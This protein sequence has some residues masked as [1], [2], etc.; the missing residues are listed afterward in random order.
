MPAPT[1]KTTLS[2]ASFDLNKLDPTGSFYYNA[3]LSG[4]FV[5]ATAHSRVLTGTPSLQG[6]TLTA[7]G[8]NSSLFGGAGK[9]SLVALGN[10]NYLVGGTGADTLVGTTLV[11]G[12]GTLVG[13]GLSSLVGRAGNDVFVVSDGDKIGGVA[14]G[15]DSIRTGINNLDL[16]DTVRRGAGVANVQN[17]IFTG[18]GG[19][20]IAGT[21]S[22]TLFGGAGNDSLLGNGKSLLIGGS[23]NDSYIISQSGSG[24]ASNFDKV[25]ESPGLGGGRDTAFTKIANFSLADTLRYG[26]GIAN[27]ENL[28]FNDG[29]TLTVGAVTLAGNSLDNTIIGAR[30]ASNF[31]SSGGGSDSLVGGSK[32]DTLMGNRFSALNGGDGDNTYY[33]YSQ[34][35]V[36]QETGISSVNGSSVI[37][38][39]SGPAPFIYD[40][41]A[42]G[43]QTTGV[44]RLQYAGGSMASLAGNANRTTIVGG[45]G[46]NYLIA[47][48][49]GASLVGNVHND[50]LND[51]G[52]ISTMSG[53]LGN[54]IYRVANT[55]T[56]I[57]ESTGV[58]GGI[59]S[60]LTTLGS[61]DL[62]ASNVAGGIGVE[63]LIYV[64]VG[65]AGTLSGNQLSN[66]ID[67]TRA[68]SV[69]IV[70]NGGSD[71]LLGSSS[72]SNLFQVSSASDLG[73]ASSIKGGTARDTLQIL[74]AGSIADSLFGYAGTSFV[75]SVEVLQIASSS[76]ATLDSSAQASGISTVIAGIG[77]DT[78]DASAYTTS[79]ILDASANISSADLLKSGS[80]NDLIILGGK[81]ALLASTIQGGNNTT[82]GDTLAIL[83]QVSG[84][85]DAFSNVS[86]VEVLSLAGNANSVTLGSSAQ[87]A[88]ILTVVGGN[89]SD[90]I[91][92]DTQARFQA[93]SVIG[94]AGTDTL[95]ILGQVSGLN[96]AFSNVSGVE[97]LSLAGNANSVTLGSSAQGAGILTVVGGNQ[98]DSL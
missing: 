95:A 31:L 6:D 14:G 26:S 43:N 25:T 30:N 60:V 41:S 80:S 74:N 52:T 9:D 32:R 76:A 93:D 97:V 40:L 86:S 24:S 63:N 62:S 61:Y 7:T 92:F 56:R 94:G 49:G 87:G 78:V 70:G 91:A 66:L 71:T 81:T 77:P 51:N 38:V 53:G 55:S 17:L 29:G 19:S 20:T 73:S 50:T 1:R 34:G 16:N 18:I 72:S 13:N 36:I 57:D 67:A 98:S 89:Q 12:S 54:D 96:D 90:R 65:L 28:T 39:D 69:T 64:G 59:D 27:V 88:G 58:S 83:G 8:R 75:R 47:G 79:I 22:Q 3:T 42:P 85:N 68:G 37:G 48:S 10:N 5:S 21:G 15:T 46:H 82:V 35:D 4:N 45:I 23:G 33:V 11:G 84:L 44:T 2:A